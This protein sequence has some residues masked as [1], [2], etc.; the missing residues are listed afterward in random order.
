[1]LPVKEHAATVFRDSPHC[2]ECWEAL[3]ATQRIVIEGDRAYHVLCYNARGDEEGMGNRER[4]PLLFTEKR[5]EP[6]R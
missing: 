2:G 4:I 6:I 1:M 5:F 3:E